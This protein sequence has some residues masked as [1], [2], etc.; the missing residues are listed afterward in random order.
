M[1]EGNTARVMLYL[2]MSALGLVILFAAQLFI[3]NLFVDGPA[4][5]LPWQSGNV[6]ALVAAFVLG[7]LAVSI[8]KS[9][10]RTWRDFQADRAA[11]RAA[12]AA[13]SGPAS[14]GGSAADVWTDGEGE[15]KPKS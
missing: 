10:R 15:Q 9:A 6:I 14:A 2:R 11:Q 12:E 13:S 3:V 7:A 1:A 4:R 8:Y 5:Y